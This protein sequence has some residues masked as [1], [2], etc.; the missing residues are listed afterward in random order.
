MAIKG[1]FPIS[2]QDAPLSL[3]RSLRLRDPFPLEDIVANNDTPC[4]GTAQDRPSDCPVQPASADPKANP[5]KTT[6]RDFLRAG[7]MLSLSSLMGTAALM[8]AFG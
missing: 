7:G 5:L 1:N 3:P 2:L 6:R 8:R 4:A